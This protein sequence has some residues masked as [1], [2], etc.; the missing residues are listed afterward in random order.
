M[1]S[2]KLLE[3]ST[4]IPP[5]PGVY[6]MKNAQDKIIYIGKSKNIKKRVKTY[7][8]KSPKNIFIMSQTHSISYLLANTEVDALLLEASLI[9]KHKPKYNIRLKDDKAYPYIKISTQHK[10]PKATLVRRVLNDRNLYFG[11]YTSS[12]VVKE[13]ISFLNKNFNIRDCKDSDFKT[14]K[15]PCLTYQMGY[16]KAPCVNKIS[17]DEYHDDLK[18]ALDFLKGKNKRLVSKI[19]KQMNEAAKKEQFETASKIRNNL[20]A[21]EKLLDNQPIISKNSANDTDVIGYFSSDQGIMISTLHI[22][23][24]R[25]VGNRNFFLSHLDSNIEIEDEPRTWLVSFLNQYYVEN[26]I[27]DEILIPINLSLDLTKLLA[28]AF[29]QRSNKK[30]RVRFP[31]DSEGTKLIQMALLHAHDKF[32]EYVSKSDKKI[33]ALKDIQ[34]RFK[35]KTLPKRIECFD[36]SMLSGE[37]T[38]ASQVVFSNGVPDKEFYRRYKIKDSKLSDYDA[39]KEVLTRRFKHEEYEIPDLILID[40]GKGQLSCGMTV[41]KEL[42]LKIPV[43]SIAKSRT[44]SNFLQKDIQISEE[45]FFLPGRKN[46]VTFKTNQESFKILTNLRDEAHRLAVTYHRKLRESTTLESRLDTIGISENKKILLL[47]HFDTIEGIKKASIDEIA[48]IKGIGD[49]VALK[50]QSELKKVF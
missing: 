35:L 32:K 18:K 1:K 14:R 44:K 34:K 25:K 4:K 49:K 10:F 5:L 39:I 2:E 45:R 28:T 22:R 29:K 46:P 40:G 7:F 50:I 43:A 19:K 24:G 17:K 48:S 38:V 12:F 13:T 8:S 11:P 26:I 42:K 16:C 31:T 9:K 6:I 23:K 27:P 3:F 36:I 30:S 37:E 21:I 20:F 33:N 15:K 47:K 41:L